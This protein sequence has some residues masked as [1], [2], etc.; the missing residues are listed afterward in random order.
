MKFLVGATKV[1]Q[2]R[3]AHKSQNYSIIGDKVYFQRRNG[4]LRRTIWKNDTSRLLY[5]FHDGF[6]GG[7]FVSRIVVEKIL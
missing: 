7:H 1:V 2:T 4:V 6:Y 5:E 3:I